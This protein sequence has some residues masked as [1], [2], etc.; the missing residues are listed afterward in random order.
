MSDLVAVARG[1]EPADLLITGA[2]VLEVYSGE[3]LDTPVALAGG[4]IA[5]LGD[6]EA[7]ATLHL[8]GV[9]LLPG[10]MDGHL[11]LESSQLAPAEFAAA[12]VTHGTTTVIADPHEICN[13]CGLAGARALLEATPRE[14]LTLYLMAPS[15]VPATP[16]E[17]AGAELGPAEVAAMLAWPEVLGLGEV[18]NFPG[19][20]TGAPE[21][22]AKLALAAGRPIDGH[23]P[24]VT[25][26]DLA[27]YVAAGPQSEHEA[28]TLAEGREKLAAGLWLMIREGS[29][30][31]DLH[32]LAPLLQ[33]PGAG[34]CL[35]VTD[36]CSPA[37]LWRRGH[38]D[39]ILR[40][41]REEGVGALAAVRAVTCHVAARFGLRDRGAIVPGAVADL[42]AVSDLDMFRVQ[43]VLKAGQLVARE[44]QLV[45]S[46]PEAHRRTPGS[47]CAGSCRLPELTPRSWAVAAPEGASEATVRVIEVREGQIVTGQSR[48]RLPVREGQVQADP[49]RDI[50]KLVVIERHG[51]GGHIGVG[52][53]RGLGLQA[54]ALG[55][56][57]A[58]D[59]HN[60][61]LAGADDRSLLT[62]AQTLAASG[63][64]QVVTRGEEVLAHLPLPWAGLMSDRPLAE[65]VARS[66]ALQQAA[67][68]LGSHLTQPLM[69]LSFLALPVIPELKLTDQGLVEVGSFSLVPVVVEPA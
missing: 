37:D 47:A 8:P 23:A 22:R 39:H 51:R 5:G 19:V 44:G 40:R 55:T 11:H 4:R 63:G 3:F 52:L 20:I 6:Y 26:K 45:K 58:H 25:G 48:E 12:V 41:A 33:G 54:G 57:V 53:V 1:S 59:S 16:L 27:A 17:T 46:L 42:V 35:L 18:M 38:L 60:L 31:P 49:A 69:A 67:A 68:A 50:L 14:L 15:C 29:A 13:V 10:F 9:T 43:A 36:D 24:G 28:T 34:R 30:S 61:L 65:V 2:R 66:E 64:G 21:V 7:H 32:A 56:T 62:A